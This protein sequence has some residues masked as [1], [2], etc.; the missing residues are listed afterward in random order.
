MPLGTKA[1]MSLVATISI[2]MDQRFSSQWSQT[3]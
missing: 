3:H 1:A 2:T